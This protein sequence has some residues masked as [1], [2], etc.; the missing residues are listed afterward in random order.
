MRTARTPVLA[1]DR[2]GSRALPS[3]LGAAV[4]A[5]VLAL[6]AA[7]EL[8]AQEP[9]GGVTEA[10]PTS[11]ATAAPTATRAERPD[12]N[13]HEPV[14]AHGIQMA[15]PW[16]PTF[17]ARLEE[18]EILVKI[19]NRDPVAYAVAIRVL[20]DAGTQQS[21]R[22]G[23]PLTATLA[24]GASLD[25]PVRF[26]GTLPLQPLTHSGL[27]VALLTACP[28]GGGPCVNGASEPL[29]FHRQGG[30]R[31]V[32][33][34]QVLCSRFHCGAL[35]AQGGPA[36]GKPEP[37][38]WRVMGGG[39]LHVAPLDEEPGGEDERTIDGGVQ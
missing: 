2:P 39:P 12:D 15:W 31:V 9:G 32:Y 6:L 4:L 22:I 13:E 21:R 26:D 30:R 23:P 24:P 25:L 37:G 11:P 28:V 7:A 3:Q 14:A 1:T 5:L 18:P 19:L 33:G 35:L 16:K 36:G 10:R 8:A 29:F 17:T 27:V 34:E 38:T 20:E